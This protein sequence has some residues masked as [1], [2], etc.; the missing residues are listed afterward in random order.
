MDL[1]ILYCL[2]TDY[3]VNN[4]VFFDGTYWG[5]PTTRYLSLNVFAH[6]DGSYYIWAKDIQSTLIKPYEY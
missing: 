2:F 3:L 6:K 5:V 4:F 1:D